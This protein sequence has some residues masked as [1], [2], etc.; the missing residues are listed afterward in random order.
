[1]KRAAAYW[2]QKKYLVLSASR[3]T[4]GLWI[5]G[6]PCFAISDA[7]SDIELERAIWTALEAS[8]IG[9]SHPRNWDELP[10]PLLDLAGV[11][12]W[13]AF[14]KG[15]SCLHIKEEGGRI[16]LIPTR[17]LGPAEGFEDDISRQIILESSAR[18]TLGASV[19]RLLTQKP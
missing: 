2:R 13:S 7:S 8:Q 6:K 12:K 14:S 9:I 5:L 3:T 1:M 19:R 18:E 10:D 4:D 15:A 17:N 11:K 16:V